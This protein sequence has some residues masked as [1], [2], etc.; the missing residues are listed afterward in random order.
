MADDDDAEDSEDM[1]SWIAHSAPIIVSTLPMPVSERVVVLPRP[2]PRIHMVQMP[3]FESSK[4]W[5]G[6]CRVPLTPGT[7]PVPAVTRLV[8]HARSGTS[9]V[10]VP[11]VRGAVTSWLL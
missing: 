3:L 4:V 8:V 5:A 1:N 10:R 6:H 2:F 9:Y 11:T 7:V